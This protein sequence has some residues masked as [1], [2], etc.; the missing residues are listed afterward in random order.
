MTGQHL[1]LLAQSTHMNNPSGRALLPSAI[2]VIL[3]ISLP[4]LML[5]GY[6]PSGS[7]NECVSP[8][9]VNWKVASW[10]CGDVNATSA[11]GQERAVAKIII[12]ENFYKSWSCA[13]EMS[14]GKVVITISI[15]ISKE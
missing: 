15:L 10:L 14:A 4:L 7:I 11:S 1:A 3:H 12:D 13:D 8:P 5:Y 2:M 9:N 6:V